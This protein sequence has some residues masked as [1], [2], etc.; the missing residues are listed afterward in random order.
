MRD[1]FTLSFEKTGGVDITA[2]Q[3]IAMRL[4]PVTHALQ[5]ARTQNYDSPY[6]FV[7]LPF[8]VIM[9][10]T[11][12][13]L[14]NR[15]RALDPSLI[16][17]IGIGGSHLGAAACYEACKQKVSIP[18]I[19]VDTIEPDFVG[20]IYEK[21]LFQLHAGENVLINIISKSGTTL[22]TIANAELF[23]D[24][25]KQ[26]EP[27]NYRDYVVIT[28]DYESALWHYA[29][30]HHVDCLIIP[31][32]ISGR[33]SVMS[34]VGL[35][36]L[37]LAGIDVE[38]LYH[39]A[40]QIT[41]VTLAPNN[42]NTPALM[43]AAL[44]FFYYQKKITLL[45]VLVFRSHWQPDVLRGIDIHDLFLFSPVLETLGKWYR[46]LVAE[47]LGK[48][49]DREGKTVHAGILPTVSIGTTDLHS[50]GQ[51]Y[52][53]GPFNRF[54]TFVTC[55]AYED[56]YAIPEKPEFSE[57]SAPYKN[58]KFSSMLHAILNG[59]VAVFQKQERPCMVLTLP[60]KTEASIGQFMQYAMFHVV[61][62]GYLLNLNTFDQ[63]AVE[64]YKTE[65][66]KILARE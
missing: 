30:K 21:V 2:L 39:G 51:L 1:L 28:T 17:V 47:S 25:L 27:D 4:E 7:Q 35:F 13:E 3:E 19:F 5:Q 32:M 40:R 10:Q 41:D 20:V 33:F 59:V 61:Y 49:E 44:L 18:L 38:A 58:K 54:T 37:A 63:P 23:I 46:Q 57:L 14:V 64:L 50:I 34:A 6:S 48:E 56:S 8:D 26:F 42:L 43:T 31:T 24:L 29:R 66:K 16:V 55:N 22:E 36:P 9:Q 12:N 53:G 52:L 60:D 15:K 11:I 45:D 62:L 65:T